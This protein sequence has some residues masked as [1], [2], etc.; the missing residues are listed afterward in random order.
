MNLGIIIQ[1]R[2]GSTRL[3]GKVVMPFYEGEGVLEI[4]I[5]RIA[6][7]YSTRQIILATT[8]NS[9]DDDIA[10]I[11]K[12]LGVDVFRGSE[13]NVLSRFTEVVKLNNL[14]GV[15][16]VCADNPFLDVDSFVDFIRWETESKADYIGFG[17]SP[18]HPTIKTHFGL[19]A[20]YVS[21]SALIKTSELTQEK[22][23]VEHVTNFIYG[24]PSIFKIEIH[25]LPNNWSSEK[26]I[27]F[28]LDS[29]EDFDL[30][31]KLYQDCILQNIKFSPTELIS[32]VKKNSDIERQMGDQ[33][34]RWEK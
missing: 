16:R 28:T 27:R 6:E 25:P 3:P 20:E 15:I 29:K 10:K 26:N 32:Y 1:A 7:K 23:F 22:L 24:N 19:W 8:N 21:S 4:I 18:T 30:L 9:S 13:D 2:K 34:A 33:V 11:G 5:K 12:S 14:E 31:Q 17:I